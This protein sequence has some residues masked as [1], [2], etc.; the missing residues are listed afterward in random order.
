MTSFVYLYIIYNNEIFLY[1]VILILKAIYHHKI[2]KQ[3]PGGVLKKRCSEN[4][5][6]IYR[7]TPITL[8]HGCSPVNLLRTFGTPFPKN[9]S[10]W[11]LLKIV[12]KGDLLGGSLWIL[13][14]SS[15]YFV[16]LFFHLNVSRNTLQQVLVF[17]I[18][19]W[20]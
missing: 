15:R 20:Y 4:M 8:R 6:Q 12:M 18:Y 7:R 3:P 14:L 16:K 17:S 13:F 5:E 1:P 10:W 19:F 2:Q 11:L 9:T